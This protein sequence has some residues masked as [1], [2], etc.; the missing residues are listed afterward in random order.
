MKRVIRRVAALAA[1]IVMVLA[2]QPSPASAASTVRIWGAQSTNYCLTRLIG[3]YDVWT[4]QCHSGD[5]Q[6]HWIHSQASS[7][8]S[9]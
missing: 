8:L 7:L 4:V 9:T 5:S 3:A 6:R 2:V 1:V